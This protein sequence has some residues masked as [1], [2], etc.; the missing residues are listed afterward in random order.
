MQLTAEQ[1]QAIDKGEPVGLLVDGRQCVLLSSDAY[2]QFRS[3]VE[4]WEPSTMQ[5]QMA[6]MM[7]DDWND[8][9]MSVY[10]E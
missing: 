1:I 9:A 3:L 7:A 4:D 2:D 8:P 10:D 6:E 5:R